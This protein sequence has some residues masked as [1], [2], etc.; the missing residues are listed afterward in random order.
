MFCEDNQIANVSGVQ[1]ETGFNVTIPD[2]LAQELST[3]VR[4]TGAILTKTGL[5]RQQRKMIK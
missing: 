3:Y 5:T 2:N 4:I 1:T